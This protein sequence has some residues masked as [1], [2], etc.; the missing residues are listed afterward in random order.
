MHVERSLISVFR[1][2]VTTRPPEPVYST[3]NKFCDK[4]PSPRHYSPVE[5]DKSFL[6]SA[7]YPHYHIGL[8]PDSEI[9][10]YCMCLFL[11]STCENAWVS[12]KGR[13]DAVRLSVQRPYSV[14]VCLS[15][16]LSW[17]MRKRQT[18]TISQIKKVQSGELMASEPFGVGPYRRWDVTITWNWIS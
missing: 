13:R 16:T 11:V 12:R 5:C 8:L 14:A 1:L 17:L 2:S 4:P 7:P 15:E 10:R 3:V 18:N 6:L 9:I